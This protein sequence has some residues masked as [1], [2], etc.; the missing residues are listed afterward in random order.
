MPL[1]LLATYPY[2]VVSGQVRIYPAD[3]NPDAALERFIAEHCG[4][5][6]DSGM[7]QYGRAHIDYFHDSV[8]KTTA[9]WVAKDWADDVCNLDCD[10]II[11]SDLVQSLFTY[12]NDPEA[13]QYRVIHGSVP[14][15]S[16]TCGTAACFSNAFVDIN[17]YDEDAFPSGVRTLTCAIGSGTWRK[18]RLGRKIGSGARLSLPSAWPSQTTRS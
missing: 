13:S 11:S 10:R 8:C 6:L 1:Q 15:E 9:H 4:A 7:F 17:G 5:F 16:N 12:F 2:A 3:F 14:I 18:Q